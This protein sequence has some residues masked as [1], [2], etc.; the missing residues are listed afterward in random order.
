MVQDVKELT[1]KRIYIELT[2]ML[3]VMAY[4]IPGLTGAVTCGNGDQSRNHTCLFEQGKPR[5]HDCV[6][7]GLQN[8][9]CSEGNCP[10]KCHMCNGSLQ[11]CESEY[12]LQECP[13]GKEFCINELTNSNDTSRTVNRRC[14]TYNDCNDGWYFKYSDDDKF[15]GFEENYVYTE[16][17]Y[18]EYCCNED[19]CNGLV[20]PPKKW[21]P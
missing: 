14:G 13:A 21:R 3:K 2:D 5:G 19:G 4:G 11:F 10:G 17:F 12:A 9:S 6:G 15:T 7:Q 1:M 18:C 16:D 8:G 20:N